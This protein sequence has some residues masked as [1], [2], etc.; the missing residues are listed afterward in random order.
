MR[1]G[2]ASDEEERG[3]RGRFF[4]PDEVARG[5]GEV[6]DAGAGSWREGET[7]EGQAFAEHG[8]DIRRLLRGEGELVGVGAPCEFF[9][10]GI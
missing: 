10:V 1:G 6:A 2:R 5:A 8:V 7:E 3:G 4:V 9:D